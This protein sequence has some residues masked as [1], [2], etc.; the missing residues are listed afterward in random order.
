MRKAFIIILLLTN[1]VNN[2]KKEKA[3]SDTSF[4]VTDTLLES[5][6]SSEVESIITPKDCSLIFDEFFKRF[7]QD[8]VFQKSRI[9]YPLKSSYIKDIET[10]SLATKLIKNTHEYN[11]IDFT[12]DKSAMDKEYDKYSVNIQNLE[13]LVY[14]RLLGDDNGIHVSYKFELIDS[15]WFLMEILDES[16]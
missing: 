12:K 9:K 7:S 8:S 1:C 11:Y 14:Y 2:Q 16:T 3:T 10:G 13:G 6:I 5:E 4:K 15:C